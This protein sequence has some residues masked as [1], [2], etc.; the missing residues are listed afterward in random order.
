[1][2]NNKNC[3]VIISALIT[4]LTF[5]TM[6]VTVTLAGY[7][8]GITQP[9]GSFTLIEWHLAGFYLALIL[10][11]F[12]LWIVKT[13]TYTVSMVKNHEENYVP[14]LVFEIL[15]GFAFVCTVI[16]FFMPYADDPTHSMHASQNLAYIGTPLAFI[17]S[18]IGN[19]L[20]IKK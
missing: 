14:K 3:K 17:S 10:L 19:A 16:A 15:V 6:I 1:M 7:M 8:F 4:V 12:V 5:I 9:D 13:L 2:K 20:T 18:L 11:G